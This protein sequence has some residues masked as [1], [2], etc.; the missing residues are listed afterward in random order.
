MK[1]IVIDPDRSIA[2]GQ[3][4]HV[5]LDAPWGEL[6]VIHWDRSKGIGWVEHYCK[7]NEKISGKRGRALVQPFVNAWQ[8]AEDAAQAK[9]AEAAKKRQDDEIERKRADA[10]RAELAAARKEEALARRDQYES[11]AP[12]REAHGILTESDHEIIKAMEARLAEDGA[13]P[14][15]LVKR[16]R[17]AR[18]D[19]KSLRQALRTK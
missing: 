6:R 19:V 5:C 14:A 16:R 12:L 1:I 17:D 4:A 2:L 15:E 10:E 3:T 9:A 7:P 18:A 11:E 8:K 13:L